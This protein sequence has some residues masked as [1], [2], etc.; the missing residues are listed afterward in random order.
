MDLYPEDKARRYAS[1]RHAAVGLLRSTRAVHPAIREAK[2]PEDVLRASFVVGN[3]QEFGADCFHSSAP[4]HRG[5]KILLTEWGM[6][7]IEPVVGVDLHDPRFIWS[8][9]QQPN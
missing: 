4:N 3:L 5:I 8:K 6:F 7:G 1:L 9:E 2:V